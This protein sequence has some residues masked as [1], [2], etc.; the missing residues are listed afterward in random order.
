M[1]LAYLRQFIQI[2]HLS[3]RHAPHRQKH[4]VQT[5][6]LILRWPRLKDIRIP[7]NSS[8][9]M[10]PKPFHR[11]LRA[12]DSSPRFPVGNTC[13]SLCVRGIVVPFHET[14]SH[15]QDVADFEVRPLPRCHCLEVLFGDGMS[16]N[17]RVVDALRFCP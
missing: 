11:G 12:F 14:R 13:F 8:K 7:T 3:N 4:V 1:P 5:I 9:V 2:E 16:L 10:V 6:P 17:G 15:K